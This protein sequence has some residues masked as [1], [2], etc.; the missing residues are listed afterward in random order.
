MSLEVLI[1]GGDQ[2]GVGGHVGDDDDLFGRRH[3]L[4]AGGGGSLLEEV[5]EGRGDGGGIVVIEHHDT[6]V[7]G[8]WPVG[9]VSSLVTRA[10]ISS[11]RSSWAEMITVLVRGSRDDNALAGLDVGRGHA[12]VEHLLDGL[13]ELGGVG[14]LEADDADGPLGEHAGPVELA[15]D[16][17]GEGEAVLAAGHQQGIGPGIGQDEGVEADGLADGAFGHGGR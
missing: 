8:H 11:K 17:L 5:G 9:M 7:A 6:G 15:D 10:V 4:A 13:R 12:V 3:L 16:L 14:I 1:V 2:Q